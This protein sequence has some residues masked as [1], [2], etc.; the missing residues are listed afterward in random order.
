MTPMLELATRA[1]EKLQQ[2]RKA[3]AKAA[4][5]T[6]DASNADDAKRFVA[7]AKTLAPLAVAIHNAGGNE[8][9]VR[10]IG[11]ADRAARSR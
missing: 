5:V 7:E 8:P 4:F 9:A 1:F 3:G 6:G 11:F 10:R 2:L